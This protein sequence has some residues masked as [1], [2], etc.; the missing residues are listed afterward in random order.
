MQL[1]RALEINPDTRLAFI[2]AG[3]KSR[4]MFLLAK[5]Y[6]SPV[7][8]TAS[9]HLSQAQTRLG[10]RHVVVKLDGEIEDLFKEELEGITVVSGPLVAD[11]RVQGLPF[12]LLAALDRAAARLGIPL[13]V[14]ADGA[15]QRGLKAPGGHEPA[16]PDFIGEVAVVAG[17][18]GI[19]KPL[20]EE[21]VHRPE[22]FARLAGME[23]GE[24]VTVKGVAGV[25]RHPQGGLKDKPINA[26]YY[27]I[28]N[29]AANPHTAAAAK[30]IAADIL[31]EYQAVIVADLGQQ[32]GD[33]E[34]LAVHQRIAGVVLAAGG[35]SRIGEPKQ[36]LAWRGEPFVRAVA[37]TALAAGLSPVVVVLGAYAEQV[38]PAVADLPVMIVENQAWEAGQSASVK[39][40]L[41]ALPAGTGGAVFLLVDQPQIPVQLIESL[42]AKH[43]ESLAP[44]VAPLVD[45]QRGNPV[46]FDRRTFADLHK[47][48]GDKGGR[49]LF[50]K[51]QLAWVPWVDPAAA[52]DVD[53]LEDLA[54]LL[55][56]ED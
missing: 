47:I 16:L 41:Q 1:S 24:V 11:G 8:V 29:G 44:V 30:Q 2:G 13:L 3:G 38:R 25:L 7:I 6:G 52:L 33:D 12:E 4:A 46:L 20:N 21:W 15:R 35:S 26:K 56:Y 31:G 18:W 9:T 54:R 40:G 32:S 45:G 42:A 53:T 36:L 34:V 28:L 27:A 50:S 51:Y 5:E 19:G 48:E 23:M 39:V 55:N 37:K 17:L 49:Q 10:A 22:Q 43:A 14:E